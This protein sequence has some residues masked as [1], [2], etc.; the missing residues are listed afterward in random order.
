MTNTAFI[1]GLLCRRSI[2]IDDEIQEELLIP[3]TF[4]HSAT[5]ECLDF[6]R[7]D[8]K[9]LLVLL[10]GVAY[11][12]EL[13]CRN[14]PQP[15]RAH[16]GDEAEKDKCIPIYKP[17]RTVRCIARWQVFRARNSVVFNRS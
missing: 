5:L 2:S 10:S 7:K 14:C 3:V 1:I 9:I 17:T 6:S 13:Y 11:M 8:V 4:P 16:V 12:P 15:K